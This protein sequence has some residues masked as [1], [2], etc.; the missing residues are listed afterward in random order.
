[1]ADKRVRLSTSIVTLRKEIGAS[2]FSPVG[3]ILGNFVIPF[4][5]FDAMSGT[6]ASIYVTCGCKREASPQRF[7]RV[8]RIPVVS[9]VTEN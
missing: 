9:C 7:S 1:M 4:T 2:L 5:P 3:H 6:E 8:R